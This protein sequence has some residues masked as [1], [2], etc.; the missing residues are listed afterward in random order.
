MLRPLVSIISI[1]YNQAQVTCAMLA[2]LRQLTYPNFEVI[3]IDN[4]SP[5]EDPGVIEEQFPE[6]QLIRS[7]ENL[8]FAGGNNLGIQAAKGDYCLFINNDT[9]VVPHLLEPLVSVFERNPKVG[10]ASP[11]I[12][13]YGTDNIIQYA[14]C[15]GISP[16]TGRG[17]V[18]GY[19]EPDKGQHDTSHVTS[20]I[21]GAAMMVPTEVIRKAGLMP[22]LYFLYYE[23][24]DWCEMIKRAGYQSYY[25]AGATIYHK[26]SVSVGQG[27]V[28]R[29]YYMN[30]NRLLYIR[31]NS[32]GWRF[33]SGCLF[34]LL[35]SVPK[36]S[37]V[38]AL[39]GQWAH[40]RA[41]WRGLGWHLQGHNVH[42]NTFL[43]PAAA[44]RPVA[45]GVGSAHAAQ[46]RS[47]TIE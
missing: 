30:R 29:T 28:L 41:L 7:T 15:D 21:H 18:K 26:E 33:W 40:L 47:S 24:L 23:E 35:I 45:A 34:Y 43:A 32:M 12:I 42:H 4:A 39:R 8:G 5:T 19:L 25:E 36:N 17:H 22:A 9:E 1:N 38:M 10:V 27:S 11:K 31:R 20:L 2:S 3:V 16:W 6:V 44:N 37:L 14:G 13:F 46:H